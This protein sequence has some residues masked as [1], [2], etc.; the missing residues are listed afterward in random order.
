MNDDTR[1]FRPREASLSDTPTGQLRAPAALGVE[2]AGR[3]DKGRV[4]P[5]NED[6]FGLEPPTSAQAR[7]QG[8]LLI[9]SDGM[10]GHAAGEVASGLAVETVKAAFYR[11]RGASAADAI[12]SAITTANNVIF[13]SAEEDST[14]S[15]MGCTV[16]AMVVQGSTLTVGHVGDS[17]GYLIRG[18]RA[19]QITRDH[20]WVAMQ[21]AEGI[22]TPEQAER[23]PNRSL[24]M[25][26]L[27]RQPSVEVEIGQHQLQAGDVLILCSDGLTGVV[28]DAEIGEYASRYAPAAA[29]D[30]L[31][32]LANQRGAPDN[33]TV[34]AAAIT[35][36]AGAA[37]VGDTTVTMSAPPVEALTPR[38]VK[39]PTAGPSAATT[40]RQ[41]A[42]SP[43][44]AGAPIVISR[45]TVQPRPA[46]PSAGRR[47]RGRWL[48]GSLAA[49]GLAAGLVLLTTLGPRTFST[50]DA[51]R[52][53]EPA[54]AGKPAATS[55]VA[56]QAAPAAAVPPP[57][58]TGIPAPAPT[59]GAAIVVAPPASSPATG[60]VSPAAPATSSTAA[61]PGATPLVPNSGPSASG[62]PV[63][64]TGSPP[65]LTAP[66]GATPPPAQ[67][68]V[69]APPRDGV[70]GPSD[71]SAG[72]G[73]PTEGGAPADAA[74]VPDE[75][76]PNPDAG[77][78]GTA[79][80][81][82]GAEPPTGEPAPDSPSQNG[83]PAPGPRF[84]PPPGFPIPGGLPS[85]RP[86]RKPSDD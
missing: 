16:V 66:T 54:V 70:A 82:E 57:V 51:P 26:A 67:G 19:R 56:G 12:R 49:F 2:A 58:A 62:T 77:A 27:G 15:G 60:N 74:G 59:S 50:P 6:A 33:V 73:A 44:P 17:R 68:S 64:V 69:E 43:P 84:T 23:H 45:E 14:R 22:L 21:V 86:G 52:A 25:R 80:E 18:G 8:T 47:S 20:S 32:S 7:A 37:A 1:P 38:L 9:V 71:A 85:L 63:G 30:Q 3:T 11:E 35:G 4:R 79:G 39:P 29:A 40:Q 76:A 61:R 65:A 46:D 28:D 5:G 13:N 31:V 42:A 75:T 81:P 36:P 41:P 53:S 78:P 55:P 83:P 72:A 24:L 48:A 10:G 34:L